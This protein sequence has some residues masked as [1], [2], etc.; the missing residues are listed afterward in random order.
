MDIRQAGVE[1][2]MGSKTIVEE[3]EIEEAI[4]NVPKDSFTVLD[5]I[6]VFKDMH[7]EDW[8][9][10]VERFGLFGSKRRYT[11][12]TYLSNR[13]DVYSHKPYST[14]TPFTRCKEAKFKDYRRTTKEEKKIFGSPWIAVLKRNLKI[15]MR[16]P[17]IRVVWASEQFKQ[18]ARQS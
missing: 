13:L 17:F 14:L 3:E 10:L 18:T 8:K 9:N 12:T 16:T 7:P 11:V 4:K 5:F 6:D 15:R 2:K 1:V